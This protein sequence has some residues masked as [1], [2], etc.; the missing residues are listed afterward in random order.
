MGSQAGENIVGRA[1]GINHP[2]KVPAAR[3]FTRFLLL[4]GHTRARRPTT[5]QV[6][7]CRCSRARW[8]VRH[9]PLRVPHVPSRPPSDDPPGTRRFPPGREAASRPRDK[10]SKDGSAV[11]AEQREKPPRPSV[12]QRTHLAHKTIATARGGQSEAGFKRAERRGP[13]P[14]GCAATT[15][16]DAPRPPGLPCGAPRRSW[17]SAESVATCALTQSGTDLVHKLHGK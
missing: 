10:S 2:S 16:P 6:R 13:V 12:R 5:I 3:G 1:E 7:W 17:E 11:V 9:S 14:V 8:F 15:R 4:R